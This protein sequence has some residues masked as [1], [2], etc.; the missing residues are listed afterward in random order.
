MSTTIDERVV[1]MRFDNKDFEKNVSTSMNTIEKLK[2]SLL[3]KGA[4]NGFKDID[5]AAKDVDMGHLEKGVES[6]RAK[7]S[8]LEVMG[9]TALANIT[10]SAVNAGKKIVSALTIEPIK[11]GFS[12]Y[13]TQMNAVQTI[14]ANTSS[15]GTTLTQVNKALDELNTYADKTIYNFT[16]M[17]RNIGTFTA[18]GVDLDTSVSAI[19]GIA[20]LAAVSGSSSQQASTAMYQLSQ[21]LASG[22]VKLMDWNSVVNAGMGG[23]VFQDSLKETAKLHGKNVDAMIEK[24]GSFRETLKDGWLT[25]DILTETLAKFTGDLDAAALKKQGYTDEQVTEILELGEMA[26]NAATK[27]KTLT[28]LWDTLKEAAQSGWSQSWRIIVGDFEESKAFFTEVSDTIGALIGE[29]ADA[30]NKLLSGGLSS[31]WKQFLEAGIADE[32]GFKESLKKVA[33]E[34]GTDLDKLQES[35]GKDASFED[36]LAAGFKDGSLSA[37][38]FSKSVSDLANKMRNMSEEEMQAAGYTK[39]HLE[40]IEKLE[41]GLKNGSVSMD[42]FIDKMSK[43]SG[44]ENLIDSLRNSFQAVMKIITPIKEAFSEIFPPATADQLYSLTEKIKSFSEK[45][46]ISDETAKALKGTFKGV[47]SIVK[48]GVDIFNDI[49]GG[50]VKLLGA[51]LPLGGGILDVT[52]SLGNFLTGISE[53][54]SELNIFDR[55]FEGAANILGS[56]ATGISNVLSSLAGGINK[57]GGVIGIIKKMVD[58]VGQLFDKIQVATPGDSIFDTLFNLVNSGIFTAIGVWLAK[59]IKSLSNFTEN[60]GGFLENITGILEGVGDALQAFTGSIKADTL[61]KI[62]IAIGI[63]AASLWVLSTID[64]GSLTTALVGMT[65]LIKMLMSSLSSFGKILDGNNFKGIGKATAAIMGISV[66]LLILS[67]AL[68]IMSTMSWSEMGVGLVS[69]TVG[70]GALIGAIRLLPEKDVN[71][72]AKAIKKLSSAVLVYAV[73]MKIM[74]SMTWQEMA[75]GLTTTVAGLGALVGALHLLPKDFSSKASSMIVL[76]SALVVL[77]TALKIM[78]SMS[79]QEMAIGLGGMVIGLGALIGA[80][81]LLPKDFSGKTSSLIVLASAMIVLGAALKIIGSMPWQELALGIGGMAAGLAVL[82]GALYLIP[83]DVAGKAAGILI[84]SSAMVVLGAALKIMGSMS[85]EQLAKGIS[86]IAAVLVVLGVAAYALAP[87]SPVL[88]AIGGA[89]AL[90]GIGCLA[91]GAGITLL[92]TGLTALAAAIVGSV[93]IILAGANELVGV[94]T[95]IIM[96]IVT[97]IVAC[98]PAITNGVL[99]L[100]LSV[101][102]GL[103]QY[104]PQIVDGL[105]NFII[106]LINAISARLP[107]LIQAGV[108]LLMSFFQGVISAL[109]TIDPTV[110][111]E[112]LAA[113]GLFAG[114]IAALSALVPFIPG[115]MVA[116]L[117]MGALVVELGLVLAAIGALA[118]IPGLQWL[119]SEGGNFLQ[120]IG[121]AIGQFFGGI[122][123]GF[124]KGATSALPQIGADLSAFMVNAAPFMMGIKLL[125]QQA[126][127]GAKS[128]AGIILALTGAGIVDALT[129]WLT[130]GNSIADFGKQLAEFGPYIAEFANSVSG[131]NTEAVTAAANAGKMLAEMADVIPSDW[132]NNNLTNFSSQFQGLADDLVSFSDTVT[133]NIST[134]GLTAAVDGCKKLTEIAES[135]PNDFGNNNFTNFGDQLTSFGDSLVAFSSTVNGQAASITASITTIKTLVSDLSTITIDNT[136]SINALSTFVS[137]MSAAISSYVGNS[138]PIYKSAES[139]GSSVCDGFST[140]LSDSTSIATS[141]ITTFGTTISSSVSAIDINSEAY[142]V[143]VDLVEGFINGINAKKSQAKEAA[144]KM[145]RAAVDAAKNELDINSPSKE[146]TEIG[147]STGEGFVKGIDKGTDGVIKSAE[148]MADAILK[149]ERDALGIH[150]PAD[151]TY[152]DGR[153]VAE[154]FANGIEDG[155]DKVE[156]ATEKMANAASTKEYTQVEFDSKNK[157]AEEELSYQRK[158]GWLTKKDGSEDEVEDKA[159]EIAEKFEDEFEKHDVLSTIAENAFELWKN[160]NPK[161]SNVETDR[162]ELDMYD[163]LLSEARLTTDTAK[164]QWEEAKEQFGENHNETLKFYT[165]YQ[166]AMLAE[167]EI[168]AN[169]AEVTE[170]SIDN[171]LDSIDRIMSNRQTIYDGWLMYNTTASDDEKERQLT[172]KLGKDLD[173]TVKKHGILILKYNEALENYGYESEETTSI[174]SEILENENEQLEIKEK[175]HQARS[176]GIQDDIDDANDAISLLSAERERWM[177]EHSDATAAE[178]DAYDVDY[179]GKCIDKQ[180]EVVAYANQKWQDAVERYGAASDEA[181]AAEIELTE[182]QTT[183]WGYRNNLTDIMENAV[184]RE[185]EIAETYNELMSETADLKYQIWEN[186]AGRDATSIEKN[187]MKVSMLNEQLIYQTGLMNLAKQEWLDATKDH[188]KTANEVQ[189]AY[190]KYL[191]EQLAAAKIQNEITDINEQTALR[192]KNAA[193]EYKKYIDKYEKYYQMNGLTREDL[194]RDAKLISGYEKNYNV[195][196]MLNSSSNALDKISN[197]AEYQETITKFTD[198]GTSYVDAVSS[199]IQNGASTVISSATDII[200]S[201]ID[202]LKDEE[203]HWKEVGASLVEGFIDGI[204]SKAQ[205]AIDTATQIAE[206]TRDAIES[207]LNSSLDYE[208]TIKPILDM[209]NVTD[210]LSALNSS[211]STS[212]SLSLAQSASRSVDGSDVPVSASGK[213]TT[214][215]TFTQNNYSPKALSSVEIYRQTK[216]QLSTLKGM[217]TT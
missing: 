135:I 73:A 210:E 193:S 192:Q 200:T 45:L 137:D 105:F 13:E 93:G 111:V 72:A 28:Q 12:E 186:A 50:A 169:I 139:L 107:E 79:W 195:D 103:A 22:T 199:G 46:I 19:K 99:Q 203:I 108:D 149:T 53:A 3:F 179:I 172:T 114:I 78:G 215:Y 122:V 43:P 162:K 174:L 142:D 71:N 116:V 166:D 106:G 171:Q 49:A 160:D 123:G 33:K 197:S 6:V 127:E 30:R 100:L 205:E 62:A 190:N 10:N 208:P 183:L 109:G 23:Q 180:T 141:A 120:T 21:A 54:V 212:T 125:D 156:K 204:E 5:K 87:V 182:S 152:D 16:E 144:R 155:V 158:Y 9:I 2:Q 69:L 213:G 85:W 80:L 176:E 39:E 167:D 170:R 96:S 147:E 47:F 202:T 124:A 14:L 90:L 184:K 88:L 4:T 32:E 112:G 8:A 55:I 177:A 188:T 75:V 81:H 102:Q 118:Q 95:T 161:A 97:A 31:G 36:T 187:A 153:N 143:G 173:D 74:G 178:I 121:T 59:T 175:I 38:M 159:K 66:A 68:K 42:E 211:W 65:V 77:G 134:D 56:V 217:V 18:A 15:K 132:G 185:R 136:S 64:P 63:L 181:I 131:I 1:S 140:A 110:L 165:E 207:I 60:A 52:S 113:V 84:L 128:L 117:G 216:N 35:L 37:D 138:S 214:T 41:A 150:S 206:T 145:A 29:S 61:K 157:K 91:A 163:E 34:A 168:L 98:I 191:N 189:E 44:R 58:L 86:A 194:E 101:I 11:T 20:N 51:I 146:F 196:E 83:A 92:A 57:C 198:L 154:G 126:L 130:G 94:F 148:A 24:E 67:A 119:I 104:A 129:S 133:G 48:I 201:C 89:V 82:I 26:N 40:Q 76:A 115:A 7:F 151:E 70:L 209:S 25:A 17:T 27:V 164:K